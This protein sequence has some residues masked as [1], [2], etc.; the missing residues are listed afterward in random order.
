M[1]EGKIMLNNVKKV[2]GENSSRVVEQQ[3]IVSESKPHSKTTRLETIS[4]IC[5]CGEKMK[6]NPYTYAWVCPKCQRWNENKT[7][8]L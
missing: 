6:W 2:L 1:I 8:G 4:M 7:K 5:Q 3:G